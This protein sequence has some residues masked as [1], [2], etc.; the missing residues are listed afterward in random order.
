MNPETKTC[1]SC[2]NQFVI[3][4]EDFAFYEKISVKGGKVPPPTWCP[5]CRMIRR[6]LFRGWRKL[7]KRKVEGRDGEVY[8]KYAPD[9]GLTIFDEEYYYSDAWDAFDYGRE[10][11]FTQPFFKQ[12]S[13]LFRVVPK[14]YRDA[15]S[16]T[17]INSDYCDNVG[18]VKDCYLAFNTGLSEK[19]LYGTD[20]NDS[21]DCADAVRIK[22]CEL[23]YDL[24]D[25]ETC[26]RVAFSAEC[27][28]CRDVLFSKNLIGCSDC[29]G[30]ANLRNKQYYIFNQ[31]YAKDEYFAKV[32]EMNFSS[33][34][35]LAGLAERSRAFHLEFPVRFMHGYQ[36]VNATGDY[37]NHSKNA[38]CCFNVDNLED[39]AYCQM[40]LFAKT[41]DSCDVAVA[42]GDLLYEG[43]VIAGS[44]V[45]F[46][47][48][49]ISGDLK[50]Y[51]LMD[52]QYCA[53]CK[54]SSNLFACVGLRNKQYCI[55]NK[56]YTKESFDKLRTQIIEHMN[57]M[58]YISTRKNP[59]ISSGQVYKYGEFFPPELSPFCY[60]ETL[61]Q[62]YFP[63]TKEEA[64]TR[65]YR[66]KESAEKNI[67]VDFASDELPD[68][69]KDVADDIAGKVIGCGHK[70]ACRHQCSMAFKIISQ[71]L[72][73]YRK[74]NLPLPGLCPNCRHCERLT[75]RNPLKLWHRQCRCAGEKSDSGAYQNAAKHF[76]GDN[77]CPNEFETAYSPDGPEI[78]YCEKCYQ[79]EVV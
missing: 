27:F 24:F 47:F 46:G 29:I 71:E 56:Q 69:I 34:A 14:P 58:P 68:D 49:L 22:N 28:N 72:A 73:F 6:F 5:E 42:G 63:L 35:A 45:F 59:S 61:A 37:I 11:D 12:F 21:R 13:D 2:Q 66:W 4:P 74:M 67:S 44:R 76:H 10:Y 1:Q 77:P 20:I 48:N 60:N 3:E 8:S 9:S 33:R 78:V 38:R 52:L 36:Y 18:Y 7:Y 75:Q 53:E 79:Q 32:K 31:P 25:A 15:I 55:F 62:E 26:Y 17:A 16:G 65:G 57:T 70:G 19:C 54:N 50:N 41:T 30:C 43:M 39:C 64:E 23:C 40:V 51:A